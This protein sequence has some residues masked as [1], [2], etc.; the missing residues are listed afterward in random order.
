MLKA[1]NIANEIDGWHQISPEIIIAT[2]PQIIITTE[3]AKHEL[4]NNPAF[5]KL[6][7]LKNNQVFTIETDLIS[8]AG[9][10]I[11]Q[12][13]RVIAKHLYPNIFND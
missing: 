5:S 1:Q 2:D 9:P 12:D 4:I 3:V 8:I 10:R 13:I 11:T 6:N 7:A